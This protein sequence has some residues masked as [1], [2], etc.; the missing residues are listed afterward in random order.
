M[1]AAAIFGVGFCVSGSQVGVNALS[2]AYYPT[3]SRATGVSW[4]NAVGRCGSVLGS[5]AG[6][7]MLAMNLGFRPSS[8]RWRCP[9]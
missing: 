1:L 9:P 8:A 2:A 5:M 6:G 4:S 3:S 7:S